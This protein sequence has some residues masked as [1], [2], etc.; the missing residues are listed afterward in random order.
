MYDYSSNQSLRSVLIDRIKTHF[1]NVLS[2][3]R[4]RL[5]SRIAVKANMGE[6]EAELQQDRI[7]VL[8]DRSHANRNWE[9]AVLSLAVM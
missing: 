5:H 1:V 6:E 3:T 7:K 9:Q 4:D 2:L 8:K